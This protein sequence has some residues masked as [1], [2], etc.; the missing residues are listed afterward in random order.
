VPQRRNV[1]AVLETYRLARRRDEARLRERIA[2]DATWYPVQEGVWSPCRDAGQIVET[3]VWRTR[4]NRL[5][6]GDAVEVGDRVVLQLHGRLIARLGARGFFP[7]LFQ[8]VVVRDGMIA[9]MR[10]YH[11]RE[12]AL[13]AAERRD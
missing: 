12:E 1:E 5:R 9:S 3:L 6:P 13:A 10:D 8:V 11:S 4:G 2:D 7:R